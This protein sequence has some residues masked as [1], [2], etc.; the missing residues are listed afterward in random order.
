MPAGVPGTGESNRRAV[1]V[2][3]ERSPTAAPVSSPSSAARHGEEQLAVEQALSRLPEAHRQVIV[4]RHREALPFSEIA[5]RM[6][7]SV[8]A[9]QKLWTRAIVS[10]QREL[11][12]THVEPP[13]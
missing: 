11:R 3:F 7:R 10:L 9:V 1:S 8:N 2:K 13:A 4:L 12:G 5:V 6:D